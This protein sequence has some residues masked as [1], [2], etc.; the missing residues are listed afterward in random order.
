LIISIRHDL[1][2]NVLIIEDSFVQ[3]YLLKLK[4]MFRLLL[5][6]SVLMCNVPNESAFAQSQNCNLN[7]ANLRTL[8]VR[9]MCLPQGFI[10]RWW[11]TGASL[12]SCAAGPS[13]QDGWFVVYGTGSP[14]T[15]SITGSDRDFVMAAFTGCGGVGEVACTYSTSGTGSIVFPSAVS[16]AYFIQIN[17]RSG[18]GFNTHAGSICA[19]SANI[20]NDE[21]CAAIPLTAG[22]TCSWT[23]GSNSPATNSGLPNPGCGTYLGGDVWFSVTVPASG[24]LVINTDNLSYP[25]AAMAVYSGT[26]ASLTLIECDD[27]DS[28]NGN[29]PFINQTGLTPGS[30]IWIQVWEKANNRYGGFNICV[31]D[32]LTCG[33]PNEDW[34]DAPATL[35]QGPGNF[36]SSTYPYYT[37][38]TPG[39][40]NS[41]FCGTIENN[42]WY[43]FTALSTTE[44]FPF[45]TVNNCVNND[46]IQAEVYEVTNDMM[47]C[48]ANFN[49]MSNCWN[50][51][52]QT[53]GTVTAT[54]LTIGNTYILMVDGYAGDNC[55]FVVSNWVASGIQL[56]VELI[57]FTGAALPNKNVVYWKTASEINN[58]H[59]NVQRSYDGI[60]F[61]NIG[62]VNGS[63]N[64]N[65]VLTY[66][67]E[68]H[69]IRAGVTYYRLEQVDY[70]GKTTLS[71]AIAL[72]RDF[73]DTG[74][75][76]VY[77]NPT[78]KELT[79]EINSTQGNTGIVQV[80]DSY[81]NITY[82]TF[83][84]NSGYSK[85][86]LD[87]EHLS[88]GIYFVSYKDAETNNIKKIIKN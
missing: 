28:N 24:Q 20:A 63:G 9:S 12:G 50:P 54:G 42:S 4:T 61:E 51:G 5:L 59:F 80:L 15:V 60:N 67:F 23:I 41:E 52:S 84:S 88:C 74:L 7:P 3:Y 45:T 53:T 38:D 46:G 85:L 86:F 14:I 31:M 17:R 75:I 33:N 70:D 10:T 55:D 72:D 44:V 37:S 62:V 26:C 82:E 83:I 19:T 57:E 78:T 40:L 6:L 81:G 64:S 16:T 71:D 48:C 76:A 79:L 27:D 22:S 29:M 34:C 2:F 13:F 56:P 77:P 65:S 21:P 32:T 68:D 30:T 87:I 11:W 47:G 73:N 8:P 69:S 66:E 36:S 25:N 35:T 49:S 18:G 43:K 39:N 58:D 1:I